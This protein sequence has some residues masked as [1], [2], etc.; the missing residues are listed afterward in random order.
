MNSVLICNTLVTLEHNVALVYCPKSIPTFLE[1]VLNLT[2][3]SVPALTTMGGDDD[4]TDSSLG[5]AAMINPTE[6]DD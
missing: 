3:N 2:F 5:Q 1:V 4:M 6:N